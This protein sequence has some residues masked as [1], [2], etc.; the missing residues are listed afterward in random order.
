LSTCRSLLQAILYELGLPYRGMDE[1][2]LRLAL[3]DHVTLSNDCTGGIVLLVD[4]AQHLP[5]RLLDEIRALTNLMRGGHSAV[6]LVLAGGRSLE[7][8][9]ASPKL[10]SFSQRLAVRC[11]LET[12]NRQET[13][14]YIYARLRACGGRPEETFPVE[15][16][17]SVHK[18]TDGVPRLINQV[19]DHVML[20]ACAAGQQRIE[21]THVAEAWADLQQL[22]TPWNERRGDG[23]ASVVEFGGLNEEPA[24]ERPACEAA[25]APATVLRFASDRT[26]EPETQ[27]P[28]E[29]LQRIQ[30]LL[31]DVEEEFQP[32]GSIGTEVELTFDDSVHPFWETFE[33]EE[34]VPD[35][36][37]R[38]ERPR[39]E[40]PRQVVVG[41]QVAA[42]PP[43][44]M[45]ESGE[46][47]EKRPS[48]SIAATEVE[49]S[50]AETVRLPHEPRFR[51]AD[52]EDD[53][54]MV[55]IEEGYDEGPARPKTSVVPVRR[56]EYGRL[57]ANLR[58][59]R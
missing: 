33:E 20:L 10:E 57:F 46:S 31:A 36:Y 28:G 41:E 51:P 3:I 18:A 43:V 48:E 54:D 38:T 4:E 6:R 23:D 7:E 11:Y 53:A 2:E 55:V 27:G 14:D 34:V 5:L 45:V 1:G 8:R 22:P 52:L 40:Q 24:E 50:A 59:G 44:E 37:A 35:R 12:F 13:Q 29:Q 21:A 39:E 16:C 32:A 25:D 30:R 58:R 19:C 42:A 56:H 49:E 26:D 47:V 15:T 17:Q 9:F